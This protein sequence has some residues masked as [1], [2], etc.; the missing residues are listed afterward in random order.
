MGLPLA[1]RGF[2]ET[3]RRGLGAGEE[4]HRGL[5]CDLVALPDATWAPGVYPKMGYGSS[6]PLE[7]LWLLIYAAFGYKQA[8]CKVC[9]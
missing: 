1:L 5:C 4:Q 6:F 7:A 8:R 2:A 3:V 9:V